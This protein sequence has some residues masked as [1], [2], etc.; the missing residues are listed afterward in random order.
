MYVCMYVCMYIYIYIHTYISPRLLLLFC[1]DVLCLY[2]LLCL[3]TFIVSSCLTLMHRAS[4]KSGP[5]K[6]ALGQE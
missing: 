4:P 5:D 2:A 3:V 6:V 1:C